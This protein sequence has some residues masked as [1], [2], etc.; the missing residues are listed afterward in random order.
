MGNNLPSLNTVKTWPAFCSTPELK[1]KQ[2]PLYSDTPS[3]AGKG[4]K[5]EKKKRYT[6][7]CPW[8]PGKR[9]L[10]LSNSLAKKKKGRG[11]VE[12]R[13]KNTNERK[14][15]ERV[16]LAS[17]PRSTTMV[18]RKGKGGGRNTTR[19]LALGGWEKSSFLRVK[20]GFPLTVCGSGDPQG[21]GQKFKW[22]HFFSFSS[23]QGGGEKKGREFPLNGGVYLNSM[24]RQGK[25]KQGPPRPH[26]KTG[27]KK[28]KRNLC[29]ETWKK[30]RGPVLE[31]QF[32]QKKVARKHETV[33]CAYPKKGGGKGKQTRP[34]LSDV[35]FVHSPNQRTQ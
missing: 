16:F 33:R 20:K 11:S 3:Q 10:L 22:H 28:K 13:P 27:E 15:K 24:K 12:Q 2:L 9:T 34:D 7:G 29:S 30:Q 25:R 19:K 4:G 17:L 5:R 6:A 21:R 26:K 31:C 35:F 23:W 8:Y 1:A 14:K 32:P 18:L